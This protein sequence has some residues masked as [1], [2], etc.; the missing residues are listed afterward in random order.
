MSGKYQGVAG[1]RVIRDHHGT[2][3]THKNPVKHP[4]ASEGRN[5][6]L[7]LHYV[8][9]ASQ[10]HKSNFHEVNTLMKHYSQSQTSSSMGELSK[11]DID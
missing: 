5:V 10:Q 2:W 6:S 8:F 11:Y 1:S 7:H 4:E 3:N 9:F